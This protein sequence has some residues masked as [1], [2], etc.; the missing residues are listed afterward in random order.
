MSGKFILQDKLELLKKN[1]YSKGMQYNT[2]R[3]V[4]FAEE[5]I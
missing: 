2:A 4:I 5:I 3:N 1:N